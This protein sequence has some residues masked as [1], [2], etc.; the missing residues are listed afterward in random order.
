[1]PETGVLMVKGLAAEVT[2]YK[3]LFDKLGIRA[4]ALQIGEYKSAGEP[5]ARTEMSPAFREEISSI[6]K[7][8]YDQMV[9]AIS[10]RQGIAASDAR[11][12]IDRGPYTASAAKAAGLVN[13]IAYP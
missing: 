4:D 1:M 7:D 10:R 8:T 6:L 9:D 3:K 5:F 13:R 11:E 12:L 2:F